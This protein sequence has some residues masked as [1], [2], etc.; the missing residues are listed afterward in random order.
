MKPNRALD[1]RLDTLIKAINLSDLDHKPTDTVLITQ[2][3]LNYLRKEVLH[4]HAKIVSLQGDVDRFRS[5]GI[6]QM[7]KATALKAELHALEN[8]KNPHSLDAYKTMYHD[9]LCDL[10]G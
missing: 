9:H 7:N 8:K 1:P 5:G 3:D 4:A 6:R 10:R 2:D